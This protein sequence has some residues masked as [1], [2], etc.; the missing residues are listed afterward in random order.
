MVEYEYEY[1][2]HFQVRPSRLTPL[3]EWRISVAAFLRKAAFSK[4]ATTYA[5][6]SISMVE[7]E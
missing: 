2:C 6:H 5:S 4:A 7:Y 3:S 1:E